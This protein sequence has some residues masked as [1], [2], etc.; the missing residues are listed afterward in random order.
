MK[1]FILTAVITI[2]ITNTMLSQTSKNLQTIIK[3]EK[4]EEFSVTIIKKAEFEGIV[5]IYKIGQTKPIINLNVNGQSYVF[6]N[7]K[8]AVGLVEFEDF[9]FDGEKEIVIQ[10]NDGIYIFDRKT[11]APKNLFKKKQ[12]RT[13]KKSVQNYIFT[14]RGEYVK[15]EKEK[16]ITIT[17]ASSAASG[18][19]DVYKV[20][21]SKEMKLVKESRWDYWNGI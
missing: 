16:T 19:E 4:I 11:G 14:F 18:T 2:G 8:S 21:E 10:S 17:G 9:N 5:Q 12:D 7:L 15:D 20:L 6:D 1:K 3:N 13:A